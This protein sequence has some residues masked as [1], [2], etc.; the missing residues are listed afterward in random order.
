[1]QSKAKF[2]GHAIHPMLVVFPLG[3]LTMSL[4]FDG[5][6]LGTGGGK[7]AE[8]AYYMITAGLIG[9]VLAAIPGLIDYLAIP[10]G[11]RAKTTGTYH[12]LANGGVVIFF[13]TSW[14]LRYFSGVQTIMLAPIILSALGLCLGLLSG[15][16][17]GELVERHGVGVSDDAHLNSPGSFAE[18]RT[19]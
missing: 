17:G 2:L 11:T 18:S 13:F 4:V 14:L 5:I 10:S 19:S 15:W 7:W 9:G 3:L 8:M 16:L 12:M 6:S 1:M